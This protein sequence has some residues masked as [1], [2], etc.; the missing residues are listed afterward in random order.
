MVVKDFVG[1]SKAAIDIAFG[2]NRLMGDVGAE[3]RMPVAR[4]HGI[5]PIRAQLLMDQR[6]V[7]SKSIVDGERGGK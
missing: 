3:N 4:K 5:Q 1:F 7:L 6:R 2:E